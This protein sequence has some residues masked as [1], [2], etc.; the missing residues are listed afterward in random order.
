M[1]GEMDRKFVH[2]SEDRKIVL[3]DVP[4]SRFK[5]ETTS[6]GNTQVTSPSQ[7]I[8]KTPSEEAKQ[9]TDGSKSTR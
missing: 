2:D 5:S 3:E 7:P 8:N 1:A 6:T 9:N 4:G